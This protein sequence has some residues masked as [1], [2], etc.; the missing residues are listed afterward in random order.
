M[1]RSLG[2]RTKNGNAF[3]IWRLKSKYFLV[4]FDCKI[5]KLIFF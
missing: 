1:K 5:A 3:D 2:N 4:K